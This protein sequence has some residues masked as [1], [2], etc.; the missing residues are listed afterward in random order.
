MRISM[1]NKEEA[2]KEAKRC[3]SCKNPSC[4]TGCP[5]HNHIRDF[6]YA[7]KEEDVNKAAKIVYDNSHLAFIC[8]IVCPHEKNCI[9]HC[10]LNKAKKEPINIGAIEAFISHDVLNKIEVKKENGKK[11]LIIGSGPAGIYLALSLRSEGF[12]VDIYERESHLGGVL[13]YGIPN[14][15]LP[16]SNLERINKL[17]NDSGINVYLN[18]ELTE[19]DILK[20]KENYDYVVLACG[21]TKSRPCGFEDSKYVFDAQQLLK[22][23]NYKTKFEEGNLP[24][25]SG[26]V[27]VEGCGN[28]A[29]DIARSLVRIGCDVEIVY[30]RSK[31]EAPATNEEIEAALSEGVK[32]NFLQ[33]PVSLV[34]KDEHIIL[35]MEKMKLGELDA[36]NRRSFVKTGEFFEIEANYLVSAIGQVPN[37][38]L[39][40]KQIQT[41]HGYVVTNENY[42]TN[43]KGIYAIG[44]LTLGAKT[45]VEACQS[46]KVLFLHLI[47]K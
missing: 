37:D 36:S 30:R 13:A 7:L 5:I 22:E 35:K 17:V 2:F 28:V 24:N 26:K 33:N 40:F 10:I 29:M 23:Y 3:L 19:N 12:M 14:Y 47:K 38:N 39:A 15:R 4:E 34:E 9:G 1:F 43:I 46:A 8:S 42:E 27:I 31:E 11:A 18:Q 25:L 21:L 41:D 16:V 6:I 32:F 45:V 20:L 44:D